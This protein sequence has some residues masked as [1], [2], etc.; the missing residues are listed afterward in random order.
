MTRNE[1]IKIRI[2]QADKQAVVARASRWGMSLSQYVR[3]LLILSPLPKPAIDVDAATLAQLD[4]VY[5]QL[6]QSGS[7]LSKLSR[8]AEEGT[9]PDDLPE[10]LQHFKNTLMQLQQVVLEVKSQVGTDA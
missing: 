5:R 8:L 9:I 1:R 4:E 3:T 2:S 10:E 6:S 7:R